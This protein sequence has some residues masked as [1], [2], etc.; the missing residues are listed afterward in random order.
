MFTKTKSIFSIILLAGVIYG[1]PPALHVYIIP[2]DNTKTDVAIGWLADGLAEMVHKTLSQHD[3]IYLKNK[4]GLEEIMTNRSLLLQQRP[5]TKNLLVLGKFERALNKITISIQ[6]IDLATWDELSINKLRGDYN[7]INGIN[8]KLSDTI[9]TMLM[10]YLP[11]VEKGPYPT[12]TEGKRM[13]TPP[14]YGEKAIN[15]GSSIDAAIIDLEKKLDLNIGARGE[16]DPKGLR[17]ENGE[18]VLD[19]SQ[20]DYENDRPENQSNTNMMLEVL[21]NLMDNPYQ[22]ELKRP[23]FNYDPDNRKEFQIVMSVNYELKGSIIK[24]MLTSLPYSGLKQDGNLT[25]FY[26]NRDKYNF[27]EEITQNI[28]LGKYRTI[29][30]IQLLDS[31]GNP[32]AVLVDTPDHNIHGLNSKRVFYKPFHFFS[33]LIDFTVGGWSMQVALETVEIPVIYTFKMDVNTADNISRIS[34]KFIPENELH[35]F[36]SKL[37]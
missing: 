22:V 15:V 13:R 27:P 11:K 28:Q 14:T 31:Q 21:T 20:N 37:L 29:P 19:I 26:F 8:Q 18:W 6:L 35:A 36:L 2:F 5:G 4:E 33:P 9:N 10:P 24:D 25:V 1:A 16:I 34:L 32:L 12:L 17:E 7:N 3:R 30:V 23:Q